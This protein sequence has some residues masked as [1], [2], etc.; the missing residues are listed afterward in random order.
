MNTA[1]FVGKKRKK[2]NTLK[3]WD[4]KL[5]GKDKGGLFRH[6]ALEL[7]AERQDVWGQKQDRGYCSATVLAR[8]FE[9][10]LKTKF[11][12]DAWSY[13]LSLAERTNVN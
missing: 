8:L 7:L 1:N 3:V 11:S 10:S 5:S 6:A 12:C 2:K 4:D 13:F 9:D